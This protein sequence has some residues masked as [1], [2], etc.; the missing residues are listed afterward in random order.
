MSSAPAT[1]ELSLDDAVHLAHALTAHL[2]STHG[3]RT[4]FIK[5]PTAHAQGIR[6]RRVSS[7]VDV[8]VHPADVQRL[9]DLLAER[10]WIPRPDRP[11]PRAYPVHSVTLFH[12]Q[13]TCDIDVHDRY[14]GFFAEPEEV[15]DVL[16]TSHRTVTIA[17]RRVAVPSPVAG[18]VVVALHALKDP[19]LA[20]STSELESVIGFLRGASESDREALL[21]LVES[22]R[23][24]YPLRPVL[25]ALG[26]DMPDDLAV[27]ERRLWDLR[28]AGTGRSSYHWALAFVEATGKRRIVLIVSALTTVIG[29]TRR[30]RRR[31]AETGMVR[32]DRPSLSDL[33]AFLGLVRSL[34]ADRRRRRRENATHS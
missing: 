5:G 14:P 9:V 26:L 20:R 32:F 17:H 2:S 19:L 24:A 23:S 18:A 4:L 13:W 22:T 16:W 29:L 21:L 25:H 12:P 6:T 7:D 8:L 28:V 3:L 34:A 11:A 1:T 30:A 27:H 31:A 33:R 15:L 10:G